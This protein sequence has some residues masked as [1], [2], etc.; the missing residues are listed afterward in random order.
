M[1]HMRISGTS[2]EPS[3]VILSKKKRIICIKRN[4]SPGLRRWSCLQTKKDQRR[5]KFHLV[6]LENSETPST[7]SV[8]PSDHWEDDMFL[9]GSS[10]LSWSV[11]LSLTRR[12]GLH[13]GPCPNLLRCDRILIL[14][15]SDFQS[16][17]LQPLDLRLRTDCA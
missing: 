16:R 10:Y 3:S 2:T 13:D 8:R 11:A 5:S 4:H 9:L 6:G 12:L 15:P 17:L 7:S 14:V 1:D